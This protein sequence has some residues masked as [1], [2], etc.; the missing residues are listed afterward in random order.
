M[1]KQDHGAKIAEAHG[2]RRSPKWGSVERA[3]LKVKPWCEAC[4]P[5]KKLLR[6]VQVHHVIPF[7]FVI[8]LGRPE[9]EL[10][11]R[12]LIGLCETEKGLGLPNHHLLLGH[13]DDFQTSNPHVRQDAVG[14]FFQKSAD[15]IKADGVWQAMV[16]HRP[17]V[18]AN[19]TDG[20]K[21]A[22][23]ALMDQVYPISQKVAS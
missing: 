19:M 15:Q 20:D 9:L 1:L 8:L 16:K 11:P 4:G 3:F 12:N 14:R 23:R 17:P 6:G 10:D 13:L 21:K 5:A 22:M 7:H 2:I 18:W